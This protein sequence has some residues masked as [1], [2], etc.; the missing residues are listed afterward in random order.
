MDISL[1]HPR[2]EE[3]P[4]FSRVTKHLQNASIIPIGRHHDSPMLYT[5]VYEVEYLDVHK[6]SL[7]VNNIAENQF[8]QVDEEGNIFVLFDEIVDHFVDGTE[9]MQ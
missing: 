2:D 7:A 9:T 3:G 6:A 4:N 1:V 8:L 5:I